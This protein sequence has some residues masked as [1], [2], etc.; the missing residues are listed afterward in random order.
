MVFISKQIGGSHSVRVTRL[1]N[2]RF[3]VDFVMIL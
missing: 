3:S 1:L 2:L